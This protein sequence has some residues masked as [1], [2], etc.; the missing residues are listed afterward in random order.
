MHGE[1][2]GDCAAVP[3]PSSCRAARKRRSDR[4]CP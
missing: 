2:S 1:L 4:L 3:S